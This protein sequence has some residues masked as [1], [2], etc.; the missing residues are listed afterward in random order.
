MYLQPIARTRNHSLESPATQSSL[1]PPSAGVVVIP[2][3]DARTKARTETPVLRLVTA[4]ACAEAV[5]RDA[6]L[7]VI[8]AID[9]VDYTQRMA[10]DEI[11]MHASCT[12]IRLRILEP[13]IA[14]HGARIVKHTGDG[15][16][17]E[18]PSATRA[19]WFAILFQQAVAA[20]NA[21]RAR[22]HRLAFRVGINLGDVIVE[23]HDVFG[24]NVNIAARLQE[25]AKPGGVLVSHAVAASIRDPRLQFDDAGA[26]VLRHVDEPVRGFHVRLARRRGARRDQF[27]ITGSATLTPLN[28]GMTSRANHSS[29]SSASLSGTPTDRLT[30]TRSRP[31]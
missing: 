11:G 22:R 17:A 24:H 19:V 6:R 29:C 20:W 15:C 13:G 3:R 2:P 27:A 25:G 4:G 18:F 28:A 5:D 21:G 8:L 23:P 31:G 30:V 26:L 1:A 12:D 10:D 14:S 7:A 16:L 9:T